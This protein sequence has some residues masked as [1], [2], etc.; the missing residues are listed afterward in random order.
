MLTVVRTQTEHLRSVRCV[1]GKWYRNCRCAH[2]CRHTRTRVRAR[3][4]T[5]THA[6]CIPEGLPNLWCWGTR[7][8]LILQQNENKRIHCKTEP[9]CPDPHS[10]T[11]LTPGAL[12][13]GCLAVV[14]ECAG[15]GTDTT[16]DLTGQ[17]SRAVSC[18]PR[19]VKAPL[20]V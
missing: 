13:P 9:E 7:F 18:P 1:I 17:A 19:S 11:A 6:F 15:L 4:Y 2:A 10:P 5:R 12:A 16:G 20:I 3:A 14:G 8:D